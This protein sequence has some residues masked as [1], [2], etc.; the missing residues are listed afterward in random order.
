M[1]EDT[2]SL[3]E[4]LPKPVIDGVVFDRSSSR[5]FIE[6]E[7]KKEWSPVL[8]D[9]V[10]TYLASKGLSAKRTKS[11]GP[12]EVDLKVLELQR[13]NTVDY[14]GELAGHGPGLVRTGEASFLVTRGANLVKP[15][16][17]EWETLKKFMVNLFGDEEQLHYFYS[18]AR[19]AVCARQ[20]N[21][22]I[23]GQ[24]VI[25]AGP[26][27]CGKSL[28]QQRIITPLLGGRSAKPMQYVTGKTPFNK[29][30]TRAE[31]WMM[32]DEHAATDIKSRRALGTAIKDITVN[33]QHR[34][35]AKGRDACVSVPLFI[36]LTISLNDEAENMMVLPPL[37]DSVLGKLMLFHVRNAFDFDINEP[38]KRLAFEKAM[39]DEL[40]A[41]LWFL[42]NR[43][44]IPTEMQDT[45]FGV[46]AYANLEIVEVFDENAPELQMLE[47]IDRA[48]F[49]GDSLKEKHGTATEIQSELVAAES[50][51]S[52]DARRL[53]YFNSA[54]GVYLGRLAASRPERVVKRGSRGHRGFAW[55]IYPP[56]G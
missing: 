27:G 13:E 46:K 39:G 31:H 45:R 8:T 51:V 32:E 35:H 6:S 43:W 21:V 3:E 42:L 33:Q 11:N 20:S 17:G 53:L 30:L 22:I 40:P 15:V 37:D 23:P 55:S 56:T 28:L 10:R 2:E 7:D 29:D 18:W 25:L 26:A 47:L 19:V 5:F 24:A 16:Q 1:S 54:C 12:S 36:R 52:Y 44:V 4:A 48:F 9:S 38:E 41:F 34:M 49:S 14:A 50:L